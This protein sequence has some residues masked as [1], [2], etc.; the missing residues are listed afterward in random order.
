M[1]APCLFDVLR[2]F[3]E[4]PAMASSAPSRVAERLWVRRLQQRLGAL[5]VASALVSASVP[6]MA[7]AA[8]IQE[9]I[10][11]MYGE[12]QEYMEQ[13]EFKRAADV[14]T[15]LLNLIPESGDN[16][17]IRESLILNGIGANNGVFKPDGNPASP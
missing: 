16:K 14:F 11:R 3:G 7:I 10:G 17:A 6:A 2:H 4:T 15:R 8:P 13:K 12:G 9:E 5:A 1:P